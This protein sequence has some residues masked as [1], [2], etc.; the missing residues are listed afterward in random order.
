MAQYYHENGELIFKGT[1]Y[2]M[3]VALKEARDEIERLQVDNDLLATL[4]GG[5]T[6]LQ[7][8]VKVAIDGDPTRIPFGLL[9]VIGTM[10]WA[11][12]DAGTEPEGSP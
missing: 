9:T 11:I 8:H 10:H 1:P 4:V 12:Q 3:A 2:E 6:D 5:V 7:R